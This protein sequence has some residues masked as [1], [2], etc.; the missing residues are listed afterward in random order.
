[1]KSPILSSKIRGETAREYQVTQERQTRQGRAEFLQDWHPYSEATRIFDTQVAHVATVQE[2]RAGE[3]D[4]TLDTVFRSKKWQ[5]RFKDGWV[6]TNAVWGL[7]PPGK[8]GGYLGKKRHIAA[9]QVWTLL[10]TDHLENNR[11]LRVT[12]CGAWAR[13]T[14]AAEYLTSLGVA[15]ENIEPMSHPQVWTKEEGQ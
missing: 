7:R 6:A 15:S 9:R 12:L 4:A 2:R 11:D 1:M 13:H 3:Y 14:E 8:K 10:I 5:R